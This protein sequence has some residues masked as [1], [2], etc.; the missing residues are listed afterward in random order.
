[1]FKHYLFIYLLSCMSVVYADQDLLAMYSLAEKNDPLLAQAEYQ[2]GVADEVW[3]QRMGR[4]LPSIALSAKTSRDHIDNKK[5]TYQNQGSQ[6]YWKHNFG[7][8]FVQPIVHWDYWVQLGQA[9]NKIAKS[10]SDFYFEQQSLMFRVAESYFR[11]LASED[12]LSFSKLEKQ[13]IEQQ[14]EQ[15]KESLA[16]GLR[17]QTDVYE[18]E[19]A[20]AKAVA[21]EIEA[22][23]ALG[24]NKEVLKEIVGDIDINLRELGSSIPLVRPIPEEI[25]EWAGIALQNNLEIISALNSL[26]I[27]RKEVQRQW[28]GHLP[29]IDIM[30]SYGQTDDGS[31]FGLRGNTSSIGIQLN[32]PIFEGGATQARI[33]QA[34]YEYKIEEKKLESIKRQVKKEVRNAYRGIL[35]DIS[36]ITALKAAVS[37]AEQAVEGAKIGFRE[38]TRTMVDVLIEQRTLYGNK[39]D[40]ADARYI[41]LLHGLRLKKEASN[42]SLEDIKAINNLLM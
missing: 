37:A 1:M 27:S 9:D 5:N 13:A 15:A 40:Y 17:S 8:N 16:V 25:E 22:I 19:A 24:D 29:T 34:E 11:V 42:L 3:W 20:Y 7:I 41:Y 26:E 18:A 39:T 6:D 35:S 14:L 10:E 36:R 38:G 33:H 23:N 32:L 31:S 21:S 12:R 28:N 30:G 4:L 2:Q